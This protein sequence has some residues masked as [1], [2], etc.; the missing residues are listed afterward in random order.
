MSGKTTRAAAWVAGLLILSA[1]AAGAWRA[2]TKRLSASPTIALIPQTAGSM[3]GEIARFGATTAAGERKYRLYWNAPT[4]ENDM[5]GQVSLIDKVGRG[6]YQGLI[7]APNHSLGIRAPLHRA[8]AAGLP[9]VIVSS[10]LDFPA[11]P[12]LAYIVNDDEKWANSP[13]TRSRA[14]F[15]ANARSPSSAS[16]ASPPASRHESEALNATLPATSPTLRS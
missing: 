15:T 12:N 16:P 5:A 13:S 9:V 2:Q 11:H 10:Q 8:L 14:S 4:S 7:L 1:L 3:M 6:K